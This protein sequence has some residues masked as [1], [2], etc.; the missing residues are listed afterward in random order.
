MSILFFIVAFIAALISI[1][2]IT[3]GLRSKVSSCLSMGGIT[4][5]ITVIAAV[6]YFFDWYI[7]LIII[8]GIAGMIFTS[9]GTYGENS[10]DSTRIG[11]IQSVVGVVLLLIAFYYWYRGGWYTSLGLA[12]SLTSV[13]F[14]LNGVQNDSEYVP[15]LSLSVGI[16]FALA[17]IY[18]WM[19]LELNGYIVFIGGFL[20]GL[21]L[22]AM[23][24][25]FYEKNY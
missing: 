21:M 2:L 14:F 16:L 19:L 18:L 6:S 4:L 15:I 25:V 20:G 23:W 3:V 13:L 24:S 5:L 8:F 7:P 17:T 10:K 12:T 9:I 11:F 22:K 1:I